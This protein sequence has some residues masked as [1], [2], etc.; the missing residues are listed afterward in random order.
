MTGGV[1]FR[2]LGRGVPISPTVALLDWEET[3]LSSLKMACP[4]Q[5]TRFGCP[6]EGTPLGGSPKKHL[7]NDSICRDLRAVDN[8]GVRRY[9]QR[10]MDD[11]YLTKRQIHSGRRVGGVF[12][13]IAQIHQT[14]ALPQIP[15][16]ATLL[17]QM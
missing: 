4:I 3:Q 9:P 6:K 12:R 13:E 17:H 7:N 11:I 15:E 5:H 16:P 1:I 14:N 10:R 2:G 8:S